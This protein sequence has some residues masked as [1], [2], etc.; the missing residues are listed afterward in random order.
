MWG[1][2]PSPAQPGRGR[3]GLHNR[4]MLLGHAVDRAE[5]PDQVSAI[6][7]DDF[8]VRKDV[9][10]DVESY[11]IVWII[12]NRDE[13]EAVGNIE[14][15]ITRGKPAA[16]EIHRSRHGQINCRERLAAFDGC[17]S[18]AADVLA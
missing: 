18:Q 9:G 13:H 12:E 15:C 4:R 3:P 1:R 6:Y 14:I 7:S 17:V 2:V 11:T 10:K 16:F 8:T 5:T